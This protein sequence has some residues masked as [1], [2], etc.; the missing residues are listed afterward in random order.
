MGSYNLAGKKKRL[1]IAIKPNLS[2][3]L[4]RLY[5]SLQLTL[6]YDGINWVPVG[7][8]HLT[9]KFLGDTPE[10][11]INSIVKAIET[12]IIYKS[13]P[14]LAL[15]D[16]GTFG[17]AYPNVLWV[18]ARVNENLMNLY[19]NLEHNLYELGIEKEKR[20]FKPHITL[21]RIKRKIPS[22]ILDKKIYA[23]SDKQIQTEIINEV[24]LYESCFKSNG[25]EYNLIQTVRC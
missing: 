6:G 17:G 23:Y 15:K 11:F 25:A 20:Q 2:Q 13:E 8:L 1:F 24:L 7:N 3:N 5:N 18:R 9:L 12:S 4:I 16:I 10:Y 14:E 19:H 22:A 21:C